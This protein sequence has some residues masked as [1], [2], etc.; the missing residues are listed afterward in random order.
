MGNL[1][2]KSVSIFSGILAAIIRLNKKDQKFL[3]EKSSCVV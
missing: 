1:G 2:R 3:S